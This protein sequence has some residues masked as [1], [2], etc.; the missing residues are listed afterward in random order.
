MSPSG[1]SV[2][3]TLMQQVSVTGKRHR[4][5]FPEDFIQQASST[6]NCKDSFSAMLCISSANLIR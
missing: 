5:D 1:T 4:G 3:Q 2:A 6:V